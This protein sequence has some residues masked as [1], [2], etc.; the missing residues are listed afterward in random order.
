MPKAALTIA[1][2]L[3]LLLAGCGGDSSSTDAGSTTA[4]PFIIPVKNSPIVYER[5]VHL[6]PSGLAG[7]EPKPIIPNSPPPEDIALADLTDGIGSTSTAGKQVTVQYVGYDYETGKKFV[8]SWEKG[9]PVTFTL[10]AGEVI[11]GWEEGLEGTEVGDNRELVIPPDKTEGAYPPGIPQGKAVVFVVGIL[12]AGAAA[13]AETPSDAKP[14]Q[15][16]GN[17]K[18]KAKKAKAPASRSKPKVKVPSGP[19]PKQ[20]VVDD[21]EDGKGPAAEAGDE[22]TVQYVGVN[23]K[24]GKQFDASWD[25]GEPFSF[26]LGSHAVID[27]WEEGLK[28]MKA[29]G[30][31]E[32]VIPPAMGYGAAGSPPAIPPN[33]TL[34]FVIDLLET[35]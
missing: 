16:S 30:R 12:P 29:G 23:Y 13:K 34:V 10:G 25:R 2:A 9:R 28:G 5:E 35:N 3:A 27:G 4:K 20:L 18:G 6:K 26:E 11:P 21:L 7:P 14:K 24:T 22:V 15:G 19:P 8:S 32:L 33:E 31:R 17:G 1:G